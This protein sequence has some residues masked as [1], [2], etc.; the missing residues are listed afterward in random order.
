MSTATVKHKG[1]I[2]LPKDVQEALGVTAGAKVV[3]L[4]TD[5]GDYVLRA[6]VSWTRNVILPD[7]STTTVEETEESI[8]RAAV[9]AL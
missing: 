2:T 9:A 1:Q 7:G 8:I 4:P 3:F 6:R 5:E